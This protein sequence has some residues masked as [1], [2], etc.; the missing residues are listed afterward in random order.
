VIDEH[1]RS[2]LSAEE[3]RSFVDALLSPPPPNDALKAAFS[4]YRKAVAEA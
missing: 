3:S 4:R 1:E 2:V